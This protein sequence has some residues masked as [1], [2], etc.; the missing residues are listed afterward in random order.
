MATFLTKINK[1][2]ISSN[3]NHDL[4]LQGMSGNTSAAAAANAASLMQFNPFSVSNYMYQLQMQ[5]LQGKKSCKCCSKKCF[6]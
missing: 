3:L 5:A 1:I 4:G 2:Y 6:K